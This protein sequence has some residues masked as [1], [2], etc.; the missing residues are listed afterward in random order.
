MIKCNELKYNNCFITR[1]NPVNIDNLNKLF[2]K[3]KK[4][5]ILNIYDFTSKYKEKI[6]KAKIRSRLDFEDYLCEKIETEFFNTVEL[7]KEFRI[8]LSEDS[9]YEKYFSWFKSYYYL[10]FLKIVK[11]EN[12]KTTCLIEEDIEN[13]NET[14]I[15]IV[16]ILPI[17]IK[18]YNFILE[19]M[20]LFIKEQELL[21]KYYMWRYNL[22]EEILKCFKRTYFIFNSFEE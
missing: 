3:Y 2:E 21:I 22:Q 9:E 6:L 7:T 15:K 12:V 8:L 10:K 5:L 14:Y 1:V 20:K 19:L 13:P 16:V 17:E 18:D 4:E 11:L